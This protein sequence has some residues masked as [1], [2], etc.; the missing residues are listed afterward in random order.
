MK[1]KL[2]TIYARCARDITMECGGMNK[3]APSGKGLGCLSGMLGKSRQDA[4]ISLGRDSVHPI[5]R[6]L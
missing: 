4:I 2:C 3:S 6:R 5:N 1:E